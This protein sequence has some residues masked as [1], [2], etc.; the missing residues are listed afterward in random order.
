MYNKFY[1]MVK[2]CAKDRNTTVETVF[3]DAGLTHSSY[4]SP[5]RI[6]KLPRANEAVKI[7]EILE[8]TVEFLVTGN[9]TF[10]SEENIKRIKN[11][12][13]LLD[14]LEVYIKQIRYTLDNR[15]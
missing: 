7:A 10:P 3:K 11:M 14:E 12:Y 4:Y 8:T 5:K 13:D 9:K 1:D 6:G 15:Q 2:Q